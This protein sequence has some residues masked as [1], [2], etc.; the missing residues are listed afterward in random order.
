MWSALQAVR[1]VIRPI[2]LSQ[3]VTPEILAIISRK[4]N[5]APHVKIGIVMNALEQ[6]LANV[7][8]ANL[9]LPFKMVNAM[10]FA[11]TQIVFLA[12]DQVL[13]LA[14]HVLLDIF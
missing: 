8:P 12:Q 13:M 5:N 2:R 11:M 14:H 1:A 7:L 6:V 3:T 10:Q 9:V 4:R